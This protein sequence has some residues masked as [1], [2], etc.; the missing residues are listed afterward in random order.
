[1]NRT[2]IAI[3]L[4]TPLLLS[5]IL[6]IPYLQLDLIGIHVWRQTQTQT[7]VYNFVFR[8]HSIFFPQR[9]DLSS[10]TS[11]LFYEFP[12]YQWLIAQVDL[13]F[14]YSVLY[15]RLFSFLVFVFLYLGFYKWIRVYLRME[16][17]LLSAGFLCFSPI[18][19]YY[20]INPLPDMLALCFGVWFL[21]FATCFKKSRR[22]SQLISAGLLLSL[23]TLVKL[24]FVLYG[25]IL[26]PDFITQ[27]RKK[28][29][30]QALSQSLWI[31]LLLIPALV[32][33]VK[34]IPTWK[35]NGITRGMLDNDKPIPVLLDYMWSHLVSNFPELLTNYAAFPLVLAGIYYMMKNRVLKSVQYRHLILLTVFLVF[36]YFFEMN[37]IEKTHDYYL[38]PFI[39]LIF[40]VLA[41]GLKNLWSTRFRTWILVFILIAPLTAWLR[42]HERW[43]TEDPGFNKAFLTEQK[44][45]QA[46]VP[47]NAKCIVDFDDSRFIALYYLKRFGYSLFKN[48]IN[49]DKLRFCYNKGARFL[50]T[51][52]ANFKTSDFPEFQMQ[53]R[54]SGQLQVYQLEKP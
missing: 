10:G 21:Y 41:Y 43:N 39:P 47:E 1:M 4:L 7:L 32:W 14:G 29:F 53:K 9:F 38:L 25:L 17:A 2:R 45:L 8:E 12:L 28:K 42:I 33:Y 35:H 15:S 24:P 20:C 5:F 48:E 22:N 51:Q 27:F 18:L 3:L 26:L 46:I 6:H 34:A 19:F 40:C 54:Y 13:L 52:N 31:L 16:L 36:Y 11:L 30:G 37:M 44:N 49:P 50:I 23:A